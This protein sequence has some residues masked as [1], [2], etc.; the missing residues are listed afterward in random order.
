MKQIGGSNIFKTCPEK[1][2][3]FI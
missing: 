2:F 3:R 1:V